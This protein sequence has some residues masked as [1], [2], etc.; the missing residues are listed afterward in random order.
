MRRHKDGL[1]INVASM[2]GRVVGVMSGPAYV[3]AKHGMVAMSHTLNME[4]C[5]NGIRS[6][7]ICPGEVATPILDKRPVPVSAEERARMVQPADVGDL[8][9][10]VALLPAHV[11]LN[12][13]HI[14]PTWNR[15]YVAA[16][17]Q[18]HVKV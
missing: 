5:V 8:V 2:A 17:G 1:I 14:T 16:L 7:V 9:L 11:C 3:A 6:T 4:E 13:V 10:Y 18:P 15:G 12:E